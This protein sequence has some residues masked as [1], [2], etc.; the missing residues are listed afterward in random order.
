[1]TADPPARDIDEVIGALDGIVERAREDG[2]PVGYFAVLYRAVTA[3]VRDGIASG[4]FDDGE[5]MERLDVAF[6]N[7][8]LA[9]VAA[10]R[11]GGGTTRSWGLS[12]EVAGAPTAIV[13]QHLLVGI[14]AHIN[15]DLGI[16]AGETAPGGALPDLRRDFDR[17][18]EILAA[19]MARSQAALAT[20][21]PWLGMLDTFGGRTDD[22]MVRF[23]IEIARSQ[24][25]RF[26]TQLAVLDPSAWGPLVDARDEHVTRIGRA[27]RRPG[28]LTPV[29]WLIRLRE[30]KDVRRN[31]E[32]LDTVAPPSLAEVDAEI[33]VEPG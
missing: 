8:Y 2:D 33:D 10:H 30:S 21:S 17:I 12:F 19:M 27:V 32:V 16:A 9:A 23:S 25:W 31:L 18:N 26:A 3:K 11:V 20:I 1:M 24:A 29:V 5:R 7:R 13:L 22:E 14:N 28:R 4:F 15:L 6:A